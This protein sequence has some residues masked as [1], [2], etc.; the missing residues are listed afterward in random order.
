MWPHGIY[1][2]DFGLYGYV[3]CDFKQNCITTQYGHWE[4]AYGAKTTSKTEVVDQ[5]TN[6]GE[7]HSPASLAATHYGY[8]NVSTCYGARIEIV[9]ST[10]DGIW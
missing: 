7:A 1:R 10:K 9:T 3:R 4:L 5:Y 6:Y 2:Q 8:A